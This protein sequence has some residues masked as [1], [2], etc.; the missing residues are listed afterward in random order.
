VHI[1]ALPLLAPKRRLVLRRS[2]TP[3]KRP[4]EQ[5]S[6]LSTT[7]GGMIPMVLQRDTTRQAVRVYAESRQQQDSPVLQQPVLELLLLLPLP[8]RPSSLTASAAA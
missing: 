5:P 3:V 2:N 6:W 8:H 4:V 1:L 7:T